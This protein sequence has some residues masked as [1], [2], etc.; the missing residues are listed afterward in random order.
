MSRDRR[1]DDGDADE[2]TDADDA[3]DRSGRLGFRLPPVRLP[4][5]FPDDF[6]IVLPASDGARRIDVPAPLLFAAVLAFDALDAALALGLAGPAGVAGGPGWARVVVGTV[7]A[8]LVADVY[9]VLYV[10]E[11]VAIATGA[12]ALTAVPSLALLTAVRALR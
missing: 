10:W 4:P 8:A 2:R 6:R 7:F 9:G 3:A 11:G 5:L 12:G 1:D